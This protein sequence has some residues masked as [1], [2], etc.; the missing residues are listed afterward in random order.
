MAKDKRRTMGTDLNEVDLKD[1][2]TLTDQER[3]ALGQAKTDP[4][5]KSA[6]RKKAM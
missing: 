1:M 3:E 2:D 5:T 4:V 6:R